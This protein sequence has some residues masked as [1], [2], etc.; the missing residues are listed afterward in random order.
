MDLTPPWRC[1]D[2][3]QYLH[4][5]HNSFLAQLHFEDVLNWHHRCTMQTPSNEPTRPI[6]LA[7]LWTGSSTDTCGLL[8]PVK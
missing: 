3:V 6:C 5:Y 2:I 7:V 1:L 8:L 4:S